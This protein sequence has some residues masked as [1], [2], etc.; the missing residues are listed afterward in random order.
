M[1]I[2][3]TNGLLSAPVFELPTI[4]D[5]PCQ[6]LLDVFF[7]SP[8][9]KAAERNALVVRAKA[10]CAACPYAP[11]CLAGALERQE[12]DGVWGGELLRDGE[13]VDAY[14]GPGRPRK[15]PVPV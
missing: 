13:I 5:A 7:P 3:V 1:T 6:G 9:L 14:V 11:E 10:L 15:H 2:I 12:V 8:S 4:T